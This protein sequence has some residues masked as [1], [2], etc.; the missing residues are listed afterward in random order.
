[1]KDSDLFFQASL[2]CPFIGCSHNTLYTLT[3]G[4]NYLS[5]TPMYGFDLRFLFHCLYDKLAISLS[6]YVGWHTLTYGQEHLRGQS[7]IWMDD[8]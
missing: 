6:P 4:Q 7:H 5:L 2:T 8:V 3:Y 1:M